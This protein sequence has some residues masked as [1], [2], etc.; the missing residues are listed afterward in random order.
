MNWKDDRTISVHNL[1]IID[2]SQSQ[3]K[4]RRCTAHRPSSFDG[5]ILPDQENA[6]PTIDGAFIE[7]RTKP[8][9]SLIFP[10][11]FHSISLKLFNDNDHRIIFKLK[12]TQ[13]EVLAS[14]PARGFIAAHSFVECH[15][16]PIEIPCRMSLVVQYSPSVNSDENYVNQ[17]TRL[18]QENIRLKKFHCIFEDQ[19]ANSSLQR[20]EPQ[21]L[22]RPLLC[23]LAT[24]TLLT[25]FIYLRK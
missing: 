22:I 21:S 8:S 3:P 17:W 11:S 6:L 12:T 14:Q 15:L 2:I 19:P 10:A 25:T 4:Y 5:H 7:L 23:T 18:K 13:P 16:T 20:A 24:V 1:P 9:K